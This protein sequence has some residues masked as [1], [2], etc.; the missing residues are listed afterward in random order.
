MSLLPWIAGSY[1]L[2]V[3]TWVFYLAVMSLAPYRHDLHPVAKVHGYA[4][5]GIGL[6][7]DLLLNVVV[8]SVLFLKYPQ[9]W[10]LTGRLSRYIT[11]QEEK[12]WRRVLAGWIC[13][14]LLDQ[15][16][17]KGIHCK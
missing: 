16:D 1:L 2:F 14:H 9:D 12:K 8:C 10:L 3:V 4:L 15:F 11:D 6:V 5:L 17:P 7:L 13:S